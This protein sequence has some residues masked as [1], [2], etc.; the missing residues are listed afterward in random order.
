MLQIKL[1]YLYKINVG[2][3]SIHIV[4]V[5]FIVNDKI[6]VNDNNISPI[7]AF[8]EPHFKTDACINISLQIQWLIQCIENFNMYTKSAFESYLICILVHIIS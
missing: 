4:N 8:S 3:C 1:V 7:P 5:R 2:N 6:I